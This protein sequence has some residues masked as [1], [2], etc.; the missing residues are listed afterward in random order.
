MIIHGTALVSL[1]LLAGLATGRLLGGA[2]GVDADVGGVGIAMLLL[3]GNPLR[4]LAP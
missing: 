4:Y 1:C 2:L 3:I